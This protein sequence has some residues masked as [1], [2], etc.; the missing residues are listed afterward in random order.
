MAGY[1]LISGPDSIIVGAEA[2]H[3]GDTVPLTKA[4]ALQIRDAEGAV[5]EGLPLPNEGTEGQGAE[6]PKNLIEAPKATSDKP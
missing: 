5:F 2:Y 1:K 6:M 3:V 4:Q